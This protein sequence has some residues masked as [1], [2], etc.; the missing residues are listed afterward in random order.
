MK[1]ESESFLLLEMRE[2]NENEIQQETHKT[3]SR[4]KRQICVEKAKT[5]LSASRQTRR[6]KWVYPTFTKANAYPTTSLNHFSLQFKQ[7]ENCEFRQSDSL[8]KVEKHTPG[9]RHH[10]TSPAIRPRL[11]NTSTFHH[12][13]FSHVP[14]TN[15]NQSNRQSIDIIV[16]III[17][18]IPLKVKMIQLLLTW[19]HPK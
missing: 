5:S 12:P 10:I 8:E 13:L 18:S 2:K 14:I 17:S 11:S 6:R 4:P 15:A 19:G 1:S 9:S 16:I 3:P 7:L